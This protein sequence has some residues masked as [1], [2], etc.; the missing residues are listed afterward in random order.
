MHHDSVS[1]NETKANKGEELQNHYV[2]YRR[3]TY[4]KHCK[5]EIKKIWTQKEKNEF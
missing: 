1:Q 5:N 4:I 3:G 2:G